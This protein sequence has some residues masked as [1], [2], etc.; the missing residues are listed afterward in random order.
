[1]QVTIEKKDVRDTIAKVNQL[2]RGCLRGMSTFIIEAKDLGE[3]STA[4]ITGINPSIRTV[5][6]VPANVKELGSA[7]F[8]LDSPVGEVMTAFSGDITL[9]TIGE[10]IKVSSGA[11]SEAIVVQVAKKEWMDAVGQDANT[12]TVKLNKTAFFDAI[13]KTA[14][15]CRGEPMGELTNAIALK[16]DE[17]KTTIMSTD[18]KRICMLVLPVG[19]EKP[20]TVIL[21]EES[22][23]I[24][25]K[26]LGDGEEMTLDISDKMVTAR[27]GNTATSV[28]RMVINFPELEGLLPKAYE[29]VVTVPRVA[30]LD[31]LKTASIGNKEAILL[32]FGD[33]IVVTTTSAELGKIVKRH[34]IHVDKTFSALF[35]PSYL[36]EPMEAQTT[37]QVNLRF[38]ST[39]GV[40]P[41][42]ISGDPSYVYMVMPMTN[43]GTAKPA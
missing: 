38:V 20:Q 21:S 41:I 11:D 25:E 2:K 1:M 37:E 8:S 30:F 22:V 24:L 35:R 16:F 28:P 9:Q 10:N 13:G 26:T 7:M 42:T 36:I 43:P 40:A 18:R 5:V 32:Q 14:F 31:S 29:C 33:Q 12:V 27:S 3:K 4:T 19:I 15:V 39:S 23:G 6:T 17:G 34:D